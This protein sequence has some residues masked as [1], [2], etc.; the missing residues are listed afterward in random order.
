MAFD[1]AVFRRAK[2]S[3]HLGIVIRHGLMIHVGQT[4]AMLKDY[5]RSLLAHRFTGHW[6]HDQIPFEGREQIISEAAR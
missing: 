6:R 2:L 4:H 5:R 3:T 1:L